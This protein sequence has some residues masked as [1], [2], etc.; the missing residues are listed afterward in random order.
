MKNKL[1]ATPIGK[2]HEWYKRLSA[3]QKEVEHHIICLA[4]LGYDCECGADELNDSVKE[5]LDQEYVDPDEGV[6]DLS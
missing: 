3:S 1:P 4:P 5:M 2:M 6:E